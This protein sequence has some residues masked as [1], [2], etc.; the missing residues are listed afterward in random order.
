MGLNLTPFTVS[1]QRQPRTWRTRVFQ[2]RRELYLL[3]KTHIDSLGSKC[4]EPFSYCHW[5]WQK[6]STFTAREGVLP[7][8]LFKWLYANNGRTVM[9]D[10]WATL[11]LLNQN[12]QTKHDFF[13]WPILK[14]IL[15]ELSWK[16]NT[17]D[18]KIFNTPRV[19]FRIQ[20]VSTYLKTKYWK[21]A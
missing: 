1:K 19:L 11:V 7:I 5:L 17:V 13:Y 10:Y 16:N 15:S 12:I 14:I 8:L 9:S 3:W 21:H 6:A 2:F 4:L 20:H 18:E